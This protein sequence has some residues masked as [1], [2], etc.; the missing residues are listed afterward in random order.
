MT[1]RDYL[2]VMSLATLAAWAG[3]IVV[4]V[5]ID[6]TAA[7]MLGFTFFYLT[8]AVALLGSFSIIGAAVRTWIR[9]DE[10]VSRHVARAFRH[11]I[12]FSGL[13]IGS[14]ILL[15][16]QLLTWWVMILLVLL[17]ALIE[18]AFLSAGRPRSV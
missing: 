1:F 2:I 14:L 8:L 5:S 10:L 3:W 17:L 6:P 11:G 18:L 16:R 9:P 13:V 12:L 4:L 15:S 7:G